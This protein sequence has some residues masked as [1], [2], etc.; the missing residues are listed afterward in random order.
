MNFSYCLGGL[1]FRITINLLQH[2]MFYSNYMHALPCLSKL[3]SEYLVAVACNQG[4]EKW[5]NFCSIFNVPHAA[6][7]KN[8]FIHF[9]NFWDL[10]GSLFTFT[11]SFVLFIYC[12]IYKK[13]SLKWMYYIVLPKLIDRYSRNKKASV[14]KIMSQRLD[15]NKWMEHFWLKKS[16]NWC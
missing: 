3:C 5:N 16:G 2:V 14:V 9:L 7:T 13:V 12:Q 15:D 6:C 11:F 4:D 8:F 1:H 10:F